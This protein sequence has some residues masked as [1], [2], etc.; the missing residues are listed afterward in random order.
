MKTEKITVGI[1][2]HSK[3]AEGIANTNKFIAE[4]WHVVALSNEDPHSVIEVFLERK[5]P[6][7]PAPK[8]NDLPYVDPTEYEDG[9]AD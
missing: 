6:E 9:E 2:G 1:S 8:R 4:G 7:P 5:I 3:G